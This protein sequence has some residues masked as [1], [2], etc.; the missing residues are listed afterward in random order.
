MR[1][2]WTGQINLKIL[3]GYSIN[4]LSIWP[5]MHY[6]WFPTRK[7]SKTTIFSFQLQLFS[8]CIV[9]NTRCWKQPNASFEIFRYIWPVHVHVKT[10]KVDLKKKPP[11]K[12]IFFC[13]FFLSTRQV[14]MKN[15]VECYKDFFGY[16][17]ALKTNCVGLVQLD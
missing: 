6:P 9:F 7:A 13:L 16:F 17:N 8:P 11:W 12:K 15:G 5:F 3:L 4:Y 10:D 1:Y 14:G 2:T